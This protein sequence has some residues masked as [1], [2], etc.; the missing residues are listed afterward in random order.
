MGVE[1]TEHQCRFEYGLNT[2]H[3]HRE[4]HLFVGYQQLVENGSYPAKQAKQGYNA[5]A[6]PYL[7]ELIMRNRK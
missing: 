1:H 2:L 4:G 5:Q 3:L 7:E 6:S